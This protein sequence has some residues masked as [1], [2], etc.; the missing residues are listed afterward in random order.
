MTRRCECGCGLPLNGRRNQRYATNA[1]RMRDRR[2]A[3][4]LPELAE[5]RE[6]APPAPNG[7]PGRT[8]AGLEVWIAR[9]TV[10]LPESVV[11][12]AR[13][14]ADEVDK[15]PDCSPIWGRYLE[16][17]RQLQE[18]EQQA[19]A[20]GK[21]IERVYQSMLLIRADG[22][23]RHE[24]YKRAVEL[25]EPNPEVWEKTIPIGCLHDQHSWRPPNMHGAEVCRWCDTVKSR[26]RWKPLNTGA[27]V[28]I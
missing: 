3:E 24:Q 8:R 27:T 21:E 2:A 6:T 4:Q 1:C 26:V 7:S 12:A 17:L 13:S 15:E 23:W 22:E 10:E 25:G 14:L 19:I 5:P 28:G 9:Q 11:E 20:W 16:C 18:P